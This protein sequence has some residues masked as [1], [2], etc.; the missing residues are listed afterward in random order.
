[1]FQKSIK[2]VCASAAGEF[3]DTTYTLMVYT[4]LR[5]MC[6]SGHDAYFSGVF[7]GTS[8]LKL[9]SSFCSGASCR[10]PPNFFIY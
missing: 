3:D 7:I 10:T 2:F 4:L 1:M 9:V 8:G 5:V 6:I